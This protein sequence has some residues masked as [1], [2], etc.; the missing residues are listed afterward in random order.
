MYCDP[1]KAAI[2]RCLLDDELED[3]LTDDPLEAGVH[4]VPLHMITP[5]NFKD[6]LSK[7]KGR[8]TK[9]VGFRPTGWTYTPQTG[10]DTVASIPHVI[11]REQGRTFT[12][13]N[14][15]PM[16]NST[17]SLMLYGVPYS[18]HSSFFELTCFALS[19]HWGKMIA[20]VNV[21]NAKS[22]GKMEKWFEKWQAERIRR[23]K[24]PGEQDVVQYRCS[25][26]W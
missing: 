15:R 7:W 9:A 4:V 6:Y 13:V 21:G 18:E 19:L 12:H 17:P 8:W 26:H 25:N 22:R 11:S 16:R 14:L 23:L 20:T 10:A 2:L 24:A 1:R 5:D 3:L